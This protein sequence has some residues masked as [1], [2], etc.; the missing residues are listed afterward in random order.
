MQMV[1]SVLMAFPVVMFVVMAAIGLYLG[2]RGNR[3]AR[4][5]AS[6]CFC[7]YLRVA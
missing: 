5:R 1:G 6:S 7:G 2:F 4:L 3:E